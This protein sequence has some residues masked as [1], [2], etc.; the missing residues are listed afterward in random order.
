[1]RIPDELGDRI[2]KEVNN[3]KLTVLRDTAKILSDRYMNA[4][5]T[6]QSL[7]NKDIEVLAYSIIR[8]PAT[9]GAINKA[10]EET[11]KKYNP[12]IKTVLDLGVLNF[13]LIKTLS[14]KLTFICL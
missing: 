4:K 14:P 6:G 10:L 9:F 13:P 12:T 11:L 7:L 1:M 8:M 2:E 5:R 3:I